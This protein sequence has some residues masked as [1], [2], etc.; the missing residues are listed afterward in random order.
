MN[1]IGLLLFFVAKVLIIII[2][3]F[4][5]TYSLI[6][7]FFKS[8]VVSFKHYSSNWIN[9]YLYYPKVFI[10]VRC[11]CKALLNALQTTDAYLFNCAIA[12]DQH[13]N[14]YMAKVLNDT[15]VKPGGPK[16]GNPD[17][18]LSSVYGKGY[19]TGKLRLFGIGV[20]KVLEKFEENHS[21]KSIEHDEI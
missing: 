17:E 19:V 5:F 14:A 3:P 1:G 4:G 7:T 6:F 16:F 9:E 13:A 10:W 8:F 2:Y 18:T 21:E 15:M 11:F 12:D 20:D